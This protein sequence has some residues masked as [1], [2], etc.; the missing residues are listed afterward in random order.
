M[1]S[2]ASS[3]SYEASSGILRGEFDVLR[4]EFNLLRNEMTTLRAD[5]MGELAKVKDSSRKDALEIMRQMTAIHERVAVVENK[6]SS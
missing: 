6:Q 5:L 4:G 3:T 1:S 2:E